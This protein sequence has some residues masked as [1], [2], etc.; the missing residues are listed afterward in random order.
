MKASDQKIFR[1]YLSGKLSGTSLT[2]FELQLKQDTQFKSDFELY[3]SLEGFVEE[4][5]SKEEALEILRDVGREE[6]KDGKQT[7]ISFGVNKKGEQILARRKM[8]GVG[9]FGLA[10]LLC[11]LWYFIDQKKF[12]QR[13]N[14]LLAMYKYPPI[15]TTRSVEIPKTKLD[16]AIHYFGLR[17]MHKSEVLFLQILNTDSSHQVSLRRLAHINFLDKNYEQSRKYLHKINSL[18]K[19]DSILITLLPY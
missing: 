13:H 7:D 3:K 8:V 9:I 4:K 12:A 2:N 15:S 11:S 17:K 16:S 14:E 10:L 19:E 18:N 6:R 5:V 1:D